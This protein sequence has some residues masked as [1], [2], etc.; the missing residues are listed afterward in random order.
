LGR[1]K[2]QEKEAKYMLYIGVDI[3]KRKLQICVVDEQGSKRM[4]M[5]VE[6]SP[7]AVFAFFLGI[8]LPGSV[9]IEPTHNWGSYTIC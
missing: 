6:N 8:S 7:D 1:N 9:A 5:R 4:D 2:T 3:H